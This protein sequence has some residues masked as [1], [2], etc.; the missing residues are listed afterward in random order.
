M[1]D[2]DG[3]RYCTSCNSNGSKPGRHDMNAVYGALNG[4]H[5]GFLY[6]DGVVCF[7][8]NLYEDESYCF[9][10]REVGCS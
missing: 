4:L 6:D 8:W 9:V 7:S 1:V 2:D 3:N 10:F 5:A